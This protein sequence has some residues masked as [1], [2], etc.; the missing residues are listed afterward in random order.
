LDNAEYRKSIFAGLAFSIANWH[1]GNFKFGAYRAIIGE[2]T[3][4]SGR[5]AWLR[6]ASSPIDNI[7]PA[8]LRTS[9]AYWPT[10]ARLTRQLT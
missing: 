9:D 2:N 5:S 1:G 3:P 10:T 7:R 6:I 8:E 4:S